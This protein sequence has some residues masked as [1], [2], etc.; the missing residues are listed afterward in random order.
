M[1][2]KY[3]LNLSLGLGLLTS[4][5]AQESTP[6]LD[7]I[8]LGGG[9]FWCIEAVYLKLDGVKSAVS[10]YM[11]G[12]VENPTYEQICTK[13]TGHIEVV[14]IDYDPEIISTQEIL[15]WFWRAHDPT[16]KDQQGND[17]GPQY[18][19]AIFYNSEEQKKIVDDSVATAQKDFDNPIV[20]YL[21]EAVTFYKA[22]KNHQNY[23]ELNKNRN[24]YCRYV[25]AP[26]LEKLKL[27]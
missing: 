27:D 10:G 20:T 23:Y 14:K 6:K 9:C 21:K 4:L 26:K 5:M 13:T 2:N 7:S 17:K 12:H 18:A 16:T 3:L 11:G 19:S 1:M 15:A 8:T 25:I 22:E 24:P